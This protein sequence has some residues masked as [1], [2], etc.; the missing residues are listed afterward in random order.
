MAN[1]IEL[2]TSFRGRISR[3]SWWLGFVIIMILSIAG[4]LVL[5][6][7]AFSLDPDVAWTPNW[8]A[9][10]WGLLLIIPYTAI[11]VKRFNDRDWPNW[12]GYGVGLTAA[13]LT[14]G[15]HFG[16]FTFG[17]DMSTTEGIVGLVLY[18][19][20]LFALIDNGFLRGTK[21]P[22]R[23]GPDPTPSA[24]PIGG[25]LP[26]GDNGRMKI[27]HPILIG[28]GASIGIFLI[29]LVVLAFLGPKG[30]VRLPNEMETYAQEY[31]N[32]HKLLEDSEE[33][34]AYYDETFLLDGSESVILTTKRLIYHNNGQNTAINLADIE[35]IRHR[36][37]AGDILEISATSGPTMKIEILPYHRGET[38]KNVLMVAWEKARAQE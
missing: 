4:T 31:L 3:K 32:E 19:P 28:F 21:G 29:V 25:N 1:F 36:K 2:L 10:I 16:F 9:T 26:E 6:P 35:D 24:R 34:L 30:G 11:T 5:H 23:Y 14:I 15:Q 12:L 8:A 37:E 20:L 13:L 38:F 7:D 27:K 33:L 17:P 22:N 18:L